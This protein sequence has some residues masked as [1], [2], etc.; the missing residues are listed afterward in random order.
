SGIGYRVSG[1]KTRYPIPD[2]RYPIRH[3][4]IPPGTPQPYAEF[5]D[6][7]RRF[8][9]HTPF[10]PR[11][12]DHTLSNARGQIGSVTNRGLHTTASVNA[13]QNRLTPDWADIVTREVPAEAI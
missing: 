9:I 2:T 5:G 11:P 10:T 7:G 8:L 4:E 13:Q 6:D 3:G 1:S 12:F